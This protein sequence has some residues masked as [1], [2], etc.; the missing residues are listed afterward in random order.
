[1]GRR[2][3]SYDVW[4]WNRP[5]RRRHRA[6][7]RPGPET[8]ENALCTGEKGAFRDGGLQLFYE[9]TVLH[10]IVKG[11]AVCGGDITRENGTGGVSIYGRTFPDENLGAI[12]HDR[13]GIV[14]MSNCGKDTNGSQFFI[15]TGDG[16]FPHLDG[17]NQAFGQ[18]VK[19]MDVVHKLEEYGS[20][21]GKTSTLVG[22]VSCGELSE[23]RRA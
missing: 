15:T 13:P 6:V 16:K 1:M 11:F 7:R 12:K 23:G 10:R 17:V 3:A 18:V 20:R 5:R 4:T 21:T 9:N 8:G 22:I 19:G 14:S 2:P